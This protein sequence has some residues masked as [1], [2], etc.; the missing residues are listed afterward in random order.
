MLAFCSYLDVTDPT[1]RNRRGR[2]LPVLDNARPTV[3]SA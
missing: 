2:A 1:L 3:G